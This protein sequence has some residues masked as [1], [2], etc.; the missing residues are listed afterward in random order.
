MKKSSIYS[1]FII[2]SIILTFFWINTESLANFSL[3]LTAFL[4]IAFVIARHLH[5]DV[6]LRLSETIVSTICVLLITQSSGGL[7]SPFFFL[8]YFLLFE[9]TFILLPSTSIILSLGLVLF[10]FYSFAIT[11]FQD[12]LI[13]L[14]LLFMTPISYF[15][16]KMYQKVKIQNRELSSLSQKL[17]QLEREF[18]ANPVTPIN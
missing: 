7:S 15:A 12:L 9:L 6:N 2:A 18:T 16:G 8:N 3:Q 10:Y 1:I 5:D 4:V 14:S 17:N 11:S 13:I